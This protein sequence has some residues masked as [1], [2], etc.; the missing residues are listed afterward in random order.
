[1]FCCNV[2]NENVENTGEWTFTQFL[3]LQFRMVKPGLNS[4]YFRERVCGYNNVCNFLK[5][6]LMSERYASPVS[7]HGNR[8]V[9]VNS[10]ANG[11]TDEAGDV[12]LMAIAC[13]V[14]ARMSDDVT[15]LIQVS[16][17][18]SLA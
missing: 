14:F 13:L 8:K 1:M 18:V 4:S 12:T 7:R 3:R 5:I 6:F 17:V 11:S 9:S 10:Q 16:V 2:Q 15:V